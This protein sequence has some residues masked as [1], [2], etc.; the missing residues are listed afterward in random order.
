MRVDDLADAYTVWWINA[1]QAT[2]GRNDETPPRTNDAV[3]DQAARALSATMARAD[4]ASKQEF[5]ESLLIQ[6]AM[7]DTAVEQSKGNSAQMRQLVAAVNQGAKR[8]GVDL[9]T[10]VLT[11]AGFVPAQ[12]SR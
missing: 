6:A 8:M 9:S 3:R 2:R 5:A 11:E 4:D 7:I 10:M 1:W 12:T